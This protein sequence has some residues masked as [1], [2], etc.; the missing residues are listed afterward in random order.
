MSLEQ[1][2]EQQPRNEL[3]EGG[4]DC[5]RGKCQG[6]EAGSPEADDQGKE[7]VRSVGAG[8]ILGF[9]LKYDARGVTGCRYGLDI[10]AT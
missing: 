4:L 7:R 10:K 1:S 3:R 9:D 5:G 6:T 2:D 8:K